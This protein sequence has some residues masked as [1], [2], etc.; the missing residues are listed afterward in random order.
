MMHSDVQALLCLILQG[1]KE[2]GQQ[3]DEENVAVVS[4]AGKEKFITT[5]SLRMNESGQ[6]CCTC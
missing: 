3:E 6:V 2:G 1:E 5:C 4:V